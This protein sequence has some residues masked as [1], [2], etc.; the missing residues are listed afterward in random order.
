[1]E[2]IYL[3]IPTL[4]NLRYLKETLESIR[5]KDSLRVLI[6][7]NASNDTVTKEWIEQSGYE[8]IFNP[9]NYGVARAW[10][11]IINWALA[12]D[13]CEIVFILNNDIV[14]HPDCMDTMIQ[15]VREEGKEAIT[16]VEIDVNPIALQNFT[17]SE[18]RYI[19][20]MH[21]SCFGLT[22]KTIKRIGIFDEGFKMGYFE[23]ND[24]HHRMQLEGI[25]GSCDTW[26][27]FTHYGSRTIKEAGVNNSETFRQNKEYFRQ[28]WGFVP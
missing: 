3:G 18:N 9:E 21:F 5:S 22:P 25:D 4:S 26:A 24:Y 27:A 28:K 12:N 1:M 8:Y 14:L 11:Q 17:K 19:P 7:D 10:N 23:D 15:A 6:V 13:D 20:N 16:G 2:V